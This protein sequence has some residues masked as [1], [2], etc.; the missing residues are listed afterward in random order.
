MGNVQGDHI[1]WLADFLNDV[2]LFVAGDLNG[3]YVFHVKRD[4]ISQ[5]TTTRSNCRLDNIDKDLYF[6]W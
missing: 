6:L 3:M 2:T 4:L 5:Y 1:T